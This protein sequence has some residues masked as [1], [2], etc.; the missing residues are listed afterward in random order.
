[1]EVWQSGHNA[2]HLKCEVPEM[3]PWVRILPLPPILTRRWLSGQRQSSA[4][5]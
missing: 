5:G 3:V 4:K 1:M 2:S